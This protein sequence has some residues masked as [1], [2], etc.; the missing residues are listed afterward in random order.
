MLK[1]YISDFIPEQ[2]PLTKSTLVDVLN[3]IKKTGLV[4]Q[5][6]LIGKDFLLRS[7]V[8]HLQDY[9]QKPNDLR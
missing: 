8:I 2:T 7:F 3:K 4:K 1:W 6:Q 5:L 9:D